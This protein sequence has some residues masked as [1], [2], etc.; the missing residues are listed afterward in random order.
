MGLDQYIYRVRKPQLEERVYKGEEI[1]S[2]LGMH[3]T[4]LRDAEQDFDRIEQLIPYTVVRDVESSFVNSKKIRED[5]HLPDNA[6]VS[7]MSNAEITYSGQA[8]NGNRVEQTISMREIEEKYITAAVLPAYIW[9]SEEVQYWRKE[10][11]IQDWIY[12]HIDGVQNTGYYLLDAALIRELNKEF[13][14]HLPKED[15]DDE[16]ALFYWEWY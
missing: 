8:E 14:E 10:Y 12:D 9:E 16:S 5:Y 13:D 3:Y 11:D 2:T 7:Y 1:T 15:P 4:F 6:F